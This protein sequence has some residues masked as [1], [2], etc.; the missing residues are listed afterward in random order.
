[1]CLLL[2][3]LKLQGGLLFATIRGW[4]RLADLSIFPSLP[5]LFV[6]P[7]V[8]GWSYV[9]QSAT[10]KLAGLL[11]LRRQAEVHLRNINNENE[12]EFTLVVENVAP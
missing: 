10:H 6:F 2:R 1:M 4:T 12:E 3:P 11:S 5:C 8:M 7:S 9:P